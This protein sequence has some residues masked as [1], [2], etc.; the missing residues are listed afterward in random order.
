MRNLYLNKYRSGFLNV[1]KNNKDNIV[2]ILVYIQHELII[3]IS[4]YIH[5]FVYILIIKS[6]KGAFVTLVQSVEHGLDAVS[7]MSTAL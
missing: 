1:W 3:H 4:C 6:A 5:T 7:K 2:V